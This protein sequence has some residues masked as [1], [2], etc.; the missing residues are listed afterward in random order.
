MRGLGVRVKALSAR[1]LILPSDPDSSIMEFDD[2]AWDWWRACESRVVGREID[3]G[4]DHR[5]TATAMIRHD[6]ASDDVWDW[7][8]YLALHRSG[9]LELGLGSTGARKWN[10]SRV[11][12]LI[13]ILGRTWAALTQYRAVVGRFAP[14]GPWEM[15]LALVGTYGS[16]LG[17]VAQ[18]WAEPQNALDYDLRPCVE[19]NVSIRF[20]LYEWPHTDQAIQ[21]LAFKIGGRIEDAWGVS[22]RRFLARTGPNE[23]AFVWR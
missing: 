2:E 3:W 9:A 11:F 20:E 23:G 14:E 6:R 10:E 22:Q 21:D 16:F 17:H 18:G 15:T 1:L 4:H 5:P 12:F 13:S 19:T 7:N 8:H